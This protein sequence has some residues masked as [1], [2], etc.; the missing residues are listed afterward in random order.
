MLKNFISHF[1]GFIYLMPL[2]FILFELFRHGYDF[3]SDISDNIMTFLS[4]FQIP[5]FTD[6]VDE[7]IQLFNATDNFGTQ[8]LIYMSSWLLFVSVVKL[9]VNSI[10]YLIQILESVVFKFAERVCK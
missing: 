7:A 3:T 2:M 10:Y 4:K 9:L 5:L 1:W 6:I 8:L